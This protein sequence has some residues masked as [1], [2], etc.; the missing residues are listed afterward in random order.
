MLSRVRVLPAAPQ[1]PFSPP[2]WMLPER[3]FH[4][5][6]LPFSPPSLMLPE[7]LPAAPNSFSPPPAGCS[8]TRSTSSKPPNASVHHLD[9][10]QSRVLPAANLPSATSLGCFQNRVTSSSPQLPSVTTVLNASKAPQEYLSSRTLTNPPCLQ[11]PSWMFQTE[12]FHSPPLPSVHSLGCFQNRVL[13]SS[14]PTA[15]VHSHWMP[16]QSTSSSPQTAFSPP[17]FHSLD[18]PE[19]STSQPPTAL[20]H[21]S[22]EL[23]EVEYFQQPPNCFQSNQSWMFPEQSTSPAPQTAS[24]HSLDYFQKQ[25]STSSSP[26]TA[27]S[28]QLGCFRIQYFQQ[29]PTA[30]S[31]P[32]ILPEQSTSSSPNSPSVTALELPSRVLP[33]PPTAQSTSHG[34]SRIEYFQHPQ[35][36]SVHPALMPS[37]EIHQALDASRVRLPFQQAPNCL[38]STSLV[39]SRESTSSPQRH[40]TAFSPQFDASRINYLPAR[41]QLALATSLGCFQNTGPTSLEM[42][43]IEYFQQDPQLPSSPPASELP[44]IEYSSSPQLAFRYTS[45]GCSRIKYFRSPNAPSRSTSLDAFQSRV[46]SSQPPTA[47]GHHPGCSRIAYF[48][49]PPTAFSPPAWDASRVKVLSSSPANC[50]QST[51]RW[52]LPEIEYFQQVSLTAFSPPAT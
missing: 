23:P 46:P 47:S 32:W 12:Y 44:G 3:V 6:Q 17:S 13:P 26:P 20:S 9:A 51:S 35:T 42:L 50:L 11:S 25:C 27:F 5:P 19:Q 16:E 34:C 1:T 28:T 38:Q 49:Q 15:S 52:M 31:Q 24:V 30:Q 7:R 39:L 21:I 41:P 33:E 4:S 40:K 37:R 18:V 43:Q 29:P 48:Q 22:P 10:F 2:P 14:P 8:R 36:A 45:L